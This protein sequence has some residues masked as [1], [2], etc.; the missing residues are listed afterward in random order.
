MNF[1]FGEGVRRS[2]LLLSALFLGFFLSLTSIVPVAQ[3]EEDA[4]RAKIIAIEGKVQ[5][6]DASGNWIDAKRGTA[7]EDGAE[8]SSGESS[9]CVLAVGEGRTSAVTLQS[10][11]KAT[12]SSLDPVKIKLDSGELIALAKGLKEGSTF[13]VMSSTAVASVKGTSFYVSDGVI[14]VLEGSVDVT[15]SNGQTVHLE[16]GQQVD[17][18]SQAVGDISAEIE[19]EI[20]ENAE[21]VETL[22]QGETSTAQVGEGEARQNVQISS[23]GS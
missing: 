14:A 6:K 16:A 22:S 13:Q 11:S 5:I 10:D 17:V 7:L 8:V 12:L 2:A 21:N 20:Q 18:A 4:S 15:F 19:A 23:S 3:A 1:H 9:S